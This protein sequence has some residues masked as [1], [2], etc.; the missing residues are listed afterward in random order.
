MVADRKAVADMRND[1]FAIARLGAHGGARLAA[2]RWPLLPQPACPPAQ[3]AHCAATLD[4][5]LDLLR[6]HLLIEDDPAQ[7]SPPRHSTAREQRRFARRTYGLTER[8]A[9]TLVLLAEAK[10]N[11]EIAQEL[12]VTLATVKCHV[13]NILGKMGADSRTAAAVMLLQRRRPEE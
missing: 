1:P 12:V 9:E 11:R 5:I 7:A 4:A 2:P 3:S 8:E 10:S 6:A 13:S